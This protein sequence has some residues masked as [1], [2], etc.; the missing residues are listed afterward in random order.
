[1]LVFASGTTFTINPFIYK[2]L[3]F[4]PTKDFAPVVRFGAAPNVL[5]VHP[6][7]PARTLAEFTQYVKARTG[8]LNYASAGNGSSMHLAAELYQKMTGTKMLHVPYVS[9]GAATADTM[10]N[11]TQLIFHLMPAVAQQAL[12]GNLRA[13]A[14]LAPSRASVLPDVP[15]TKEAGMA[16]L[17]SGTWYTVLAPAGTPRPIVDKLN[18]QINTSL[19]DPSFR[20]RVQDMGVTPMGG[21]PE[22]V[23][24]YIASESARWSEVVKSAG[25]R[26]D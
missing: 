21:T 8:E 6:S 11:R 20:K 12:A 15:T 5:V 23:T 10:A 3:G 13:L 19:D 2:S 17:E 1:V 25:I 7:M 16:G 14:V 26:I 9:P 18:R 24:S 4:D 22:E